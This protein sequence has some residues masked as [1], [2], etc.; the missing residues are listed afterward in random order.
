MDVFL[1]D[2]S[3]TRTSPVL[4]RLALANPLQATSLEALIVEA[5]QLERRHVRYVTVRRQQVLRIGEYSIREILS[6]H[7]IAVSCLGF[8]GGFTGVLG[9]SFAGAISDVGRAT[10]MAENLEA[11]SIIVVPGNRGLHTYRHAERI[12]RDGLDKCAAM[13]ER[14]G[15][16]VMVPTDT[17]FA[18]GHDCFRPANCVVEW[19]SQFGTSTIRPMIVIRG[20]QGRWRL[21]SGWR[22]SLANGGCIRICHRSDNYSDNTLLLQRILAFLSRRNSD[23]DLD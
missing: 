4:A 13:A 10:A 9:Q 1:E 5:R 11:R 2:S 12:V 3:E 15:V 8:A 21:P 19:I 22:E 7:G 17:V 23:L 14:A 6:D 18:G 20:S 16:R